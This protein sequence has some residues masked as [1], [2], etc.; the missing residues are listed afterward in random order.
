M[1][2]GNTGTGKTRILQ[3]LLM[4]L[5]LGS[6]LSGRYLSWPRWLARLKA[7]FGKGATESTQELMDML[8]GREIIVI[9]ELG[10]ERSS[11]WNVQELESLLSEFEEQEQLILISANLEL[12]QLNDRLGARA[13]SRLMGLCQLLKVEALDYRRL[14]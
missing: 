4:Q 14:R 3:G 10:G 13:T 2:C 11:A 7:S 1:L 9:D 6:G 8:L 5:I 12:E